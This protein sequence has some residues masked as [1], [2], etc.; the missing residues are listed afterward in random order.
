[1][2]CDERDLRLCTAEGEVGW[3]VYEQISAT[4]ICI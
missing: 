3:E 1:M 4:E 2:I